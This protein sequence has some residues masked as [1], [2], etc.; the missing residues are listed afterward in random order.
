MTAMDV[1]EIARAALAPAAPADVR[2]GMALA[3]GLGS[4]LG[5]LGRQRPKALMEVGGSALLDQ[6]LAGFAAAGVRLGVVNA[7]HLKEQVVAH[8]TAKPPPIAVELSLEDAPLETGGGVARALPLIGAGPFFA[9]NA[10]VWWDGS[11]AGALNALKRAWRPAAMDALLLV[12]PTMRARGYEGR[13][14]FYMDGLGRL[15]RKHEAETAP[16]LFTGAQLLKPELFADPPGEAFSLNAIYD[17]AQVSGRLFGV[18]HGGGWMDV[19]TPARLAAA[20]VA[21][22]PDRQPNLL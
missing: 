12:L 2:V 15:A 20:R 22:D 9:V 14:D 3:A 7:A 10:D 17:R 5:A 19:G 18:V 8:V 13:G 6:T 16:F 1:A 21:A 11:L 4:R